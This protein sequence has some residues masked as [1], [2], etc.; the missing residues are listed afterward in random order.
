MQIC[1]RRR[2]PSDTRFRRQA[3]SMSSSSISR[4][5]RAGSTPSTL[6]MMSPAPM[7]ACS[8]R[9]LPSLHQGSQVH[10]DCACWSVNIA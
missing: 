3:G 7:S 4:A 1:T 6:C 10:P 9:W 8:H 5:R 2:W